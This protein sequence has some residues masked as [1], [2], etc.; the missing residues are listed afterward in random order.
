M[1]AVRSVRLSLAAC[2]VL[3]VVCAGIV[4]FRATPDSAKAQAPSGQ[5]APALAMSW[6]PP[7]L[8]WDTCPATAKLPTK[9]TCASVKVPVDWAHPRGPAITIGMARLDDTRPGERLGDLFVNPGGPGGAAS[10]ALAF[11]AEGQA[12]FTRAVLDHYTLIGLDPRGV[13]LSTRIECDPA[14]YNKPVS[15]FPAT[16]VDFNALMAHN[17]AFGDSCVGRSGALMSHLDAV[18]Q[19]FDFDAARRALGDAK[20][21]FLGLSYG[22]LIGATYAQLFPAQVGRMALD[23][24]LEHSVSDITAM[25]DEAST[26]ERELSRFFAWCDKTPAC[27]LHARGAAKTWRDVIGKAAHAPLPAPGCTGVPAHCRASVTADDIRFA[28]QEMLFFIAPHPALLGL[29]GWNGLAV[30]LAKA[31]AGDA[32]AFSP[33]LAASNDD[34]V[35]AGLV[36]ACAEFAGFTRTFA[37]FSEKE[38]LGKV[39][40]PLLLGAS[41]TWSVQAGCLGWPIPMTNP[42]HALDVTGTAPILLVNSLYD[43]SDSYVW[44]VGFAHQVT[45]GVL[46]TRDGDG[47]TSDLLPGKSQTRDAIDGYFLTGKTPPPGTSYPS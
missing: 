26:Y 15:L 33:A 19:A 5:P 35:F 47:H 44:A 9:L 36:I 6:Q 2:A 29:R 8:G 14:L 13:G 12:Y 18:Q 27:A 25:S 28:A 3:A 41:Q 37:A 34:A 1:V 32:T 10:Q 43:P 17:K 24:L 20:L 40:A 38:R 39:V 45:T 7:S 30:A 46:V 42:P 11:Q 31:D 23:G 4:A 16:T 21:N 22:S